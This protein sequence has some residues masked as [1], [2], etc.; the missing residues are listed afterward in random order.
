MAQEITLPYNRNQIK[1]LNM[2]RQ[3]FVI[4]TIKNGSQYFVKKGTTSELVLTA[5]RLYA[6]EFTAN[7]AERI[8]SAYNPENKLVS[9][10]VQ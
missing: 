4:Y 6:K 10:A 7:M 9:V 1:Y 5:C 2:K 3:K 8:L